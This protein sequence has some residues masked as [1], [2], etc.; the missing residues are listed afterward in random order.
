MPRETAGKLS[1]MKPGDADMLATL[2]RLY[3]DQ[4]QKPDAIELYKAALAINPSQAEA[5]KVS[6]S[7]KRG[8]DARFPPRLRLRNRSI[9][10]R[11]I[12]ERRRK[13]FRRFSEPAD[14]DLCTRAHGQRG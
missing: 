5:R 12:D 8:S 2:G 3:E 10:G 11:G 13:L 6:R 4:G 9:R 1:K 14:I 7:C